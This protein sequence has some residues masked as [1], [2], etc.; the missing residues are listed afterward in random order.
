[1]KIRLNV[2]YIL[3][4]KKKKTNKQIILKKKKINKLKG[5]QDSKHYVLKSEIFVAK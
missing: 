2:T 4:F 5:I 1:V 3:L